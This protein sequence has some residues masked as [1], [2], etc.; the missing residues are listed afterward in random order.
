MLGKGAP[1]SQMIF[2]R[3][4]KP[5]WKSVLCLLVAEHHSVLC[6]PQT[7]FTY[8]NGVRV[9]TSRHLEGLYTI[10]QCVISVHGVQD[11]ER[12]G[13]VFCLLLGVSSDYAQPITGQVTEVTCPVI[14]RAQPELTPSKRQKTGPDMYVL[15]AQRTGVT[16]MARCSY[17]FDGLLQKRHNHPYIASAIWVY[18]YTRDSF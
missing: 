8:Q 17:M 11:N 4:S 12:S 14:G 9:C 10:T 1:D 6:H 15:K 3:K 7:L 18:G 16:L 13:P 5:A 2:W